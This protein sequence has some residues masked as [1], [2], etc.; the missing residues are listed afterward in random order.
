M[1]RLALARKD[2]DRATAGVGSRLPFSIER[3]LILDKGVKLDGRIP[4]NTI[5]LWGIHPAGV[6]LGRTIG[7]IDGIVGLPRRIYVIHPLLAR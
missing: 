1:G 2:I 6:S 7:I 5:C 3:C 4:A